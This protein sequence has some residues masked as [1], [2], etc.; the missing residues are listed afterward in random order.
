M[1]SSQLHLPSHLVTQLEETGGRFFSYLSR[2]V[3]APLFHTLGLVIVYIIIVSLF[4][5]LD[6]HAY[7]TFALDL[8]IFTQSL[9]STIHGEGILF[10]TPE[11]MSHFGYHFSP[12]LFFLIPIFWIA[13]YPET[14]LIIQ[15]I[16]IGA[17]GYLVYKLARIPGLSHRTA[18]GVEVLFLASP[19][20]WGVNIW[21]FHPVALAIPTLLI[22]LIGLMQKRWW[23]FAVGLV[24]SLMTKEDVVAALAVFGVVML[25]ADYV[26]ERKVNKAYLAISVSSVATG[27]LAIGVAT[28]SSSLWPP[29][30]LSIGSTRY[31][32]ITEP[33]GAMV[34]G[35]FHSFFSPL[36]WLLFCAYF[37]PL[38]FLP[39]LSPLWAA[40]ALFILAT[41][42]LATSPDQKML[43]Q[44]PAAAIPFL[45]I[46]LIFTLARYKGSTSRISSWVSGI[47]GVITR[48]MAFIMAIAVVVIPLISF[49]AVAVPGYTTAGSHE[50][51]CNE[52]LALIS[53]D[54]TVTTSNRIF[55][56]LCPR[57]SVYISYHTT[58][59]NKSLGIFGLRDVETDYVIIDQRNW[60]EYCQGFVDSNIDWAE[61]IEEG[62]YGVYAHIDG[63]T[64]LKKDYSGLPELTYM[65][66]NNNGLKAVIYTGDFTEE[67]FEAQY[68]S[69]DLHS[70]LCGSLI[71]GI[72]PENNWSIK[73]SGYIY[74]PESGDYQ[75]E[76][77]SCGGALLTIDGRS[78]GE[79]H[80]QDP[81]VEDTISLYLEQ[82]F[83]D[84]ELRYVAHPEGYVHLS[85]MPPGSNFFKDIDSSFFSLLPTSEND[86]SCPQAILP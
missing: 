31:S 34:S 28:A 18:L 21:D 29:P 23:L 44:Y 64:V 84:L 1:D 35:A 80:P 7:H 14:L 36:S 61:L 4:T 71:P 65:P 49:S 10:N 75:F 37:I 20:V 42:M 15:T 6:H 43:T 57:T 27:L 8:G 79:V 30:M 32:Y 48:A 45:F 11:G 60:D 51:A 25:I 62:K 12:I 5:V 86:A 81:C 78:C 33:F 22:M 39:L 26:R 3:R 76:L 46:A 19:L 58:E 69:P 67:L 66:D 72:T 74:A 9:S 2:S 17:S 47:W 52:V 38:A 59:P 40:P 82:G 83:H 56:H 77:R 24:L 50:I 70:F 13:P 55:P 41:D 16:A 68:F 85:W 63:I 54:A 53:D 73:F